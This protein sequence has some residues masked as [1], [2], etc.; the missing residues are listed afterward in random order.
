LPG[1]IIDGK[2]RLDSKIGEGGYGVVYRATHLGLDCPIAIKIFQPAFDNANSEGLERFRL[3]GV[4]ACRINHPNAITVIDF[5]IT[6]IGIA[7]LAMEL[8]Q[9]RTLEQ[10]LQEKIRL[11]PERCFE[12]LAPICDVLAAAHAAGIVHRDIKPDNIFLHQ[13]PNGEVIKVVDFGI[14]KLLGETPC[15][16][17][18]N[19]TTNL[20]L[21]TPNYMSPERLKNQPYDGQTDVYSLGIMLFEMLCGSVPFL[22]LD[23]DFLAVALMHMYQEPPSLRA[24]NAAIPEAV[25][26][27]VLQALM[28]EPF[29]RPTPKELA[30]AFQRAIAAHSEINQRAIADPMPDDQDLKTTEIPVNPSL[31]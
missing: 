15:L 14:A 13:S 2:Y 19:M 27:V 16:D 26:A 3:E 20:L 18:Q 4:S 28:K 30:Q 17:M 10:E 6:P 22:S 5:G 21:G 8:L 25:A 29:Q 11:S 7:Y 1:T 24:I 23:G 31:Q 9:G 12:I